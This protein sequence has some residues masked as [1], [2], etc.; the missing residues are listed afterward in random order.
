MAVVFLKSMH[1]NGGSIRKS[2]SHGGDKLDL[3]WL[4]GIAGDRFTPEYQ[5]FCEYELGANE[6]H[7]VF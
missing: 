1:F 2:K 5:F 7:E 4:Q 3:G 6:A